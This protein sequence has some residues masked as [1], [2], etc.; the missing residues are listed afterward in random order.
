MSNGE[1][2][3]LI[4]IELSITE[5]DFED[6]RLASCDHKFSVADSNFCPYC[7][8]AVIVKEAAKFSAEISLPDFIST[9]KGKLPAGYAIIKSRDNRVFIGQDLSSKNRYVIL[10]PWPDPV[11]VQ[12]IMQTL[13]DLLKDYGLYNE[14]TFGFY[15]VS[16][17]WSIKL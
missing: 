2:Q 9:L 5:K 1:V 6:V 8:T 16:A 17:L 7:G 4:G 13:D 11:E 10:M 12:E 15:C 14:T 3:T